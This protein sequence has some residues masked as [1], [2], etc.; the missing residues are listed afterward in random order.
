MDKLEVRDELNRRQ[1]QEES[2]RH[3]YNL[4][5]HA[6]R[7]IDSDKRSMSYSHNDNTRSNR[8]EEP[9]LLK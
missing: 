3:L 7:L 8:E 4:I 6:N 2:R 1:V 9:C 5:E